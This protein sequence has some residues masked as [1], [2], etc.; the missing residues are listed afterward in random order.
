[1]QTDVKSSFLAAT[2]TF[3]NEAATANLQ[4]TRLKGMFIG[5]TGTATFRDGGASG[6]TRLF[7][8]NAAHNTVVIP[9]EGILFTDDIH[10]TVTGTVNSVTIFYG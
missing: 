6:I 10:L 5:G 7:I 4:R 1:M 3:Q 2:G 8:D 9:G